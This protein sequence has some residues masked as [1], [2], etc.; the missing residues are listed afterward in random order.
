M[1]VCIFLVVLQYEMMILMGN[2]CIFKGSLYLLNDSVSTFNGNGSIL[3]W[4]LM[5]FNDNL[6]VYNDSVFWNDDF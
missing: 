1:V 4:E 2:S 3:L 5:I 6:I